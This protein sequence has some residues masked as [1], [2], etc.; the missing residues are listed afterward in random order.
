MF[1]AA[2]SIKPL[3]TM[4]KLWQV[5]CHKIVAP[6]SLHYVGRY[7]QDLL[8]KVANQLPANDPNRDVVWEGLRRFLVQIY[9]GV[10]GIDHSACYVNVCLQTPTTQYQTP[11]WHKDGWMFAPNTLSFKYVAAICG[12]PTRFLVNPDNILDEL[13]I[14][15]GEYVIDNR[16]VMGFTCGM[17]DSPIHSSPN[18]TSDRIF[19]SLVPGSLGQLRKLAELRGLP[20]DYSLF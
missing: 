5:D 17:P 6:K 4:G 16:Q 9:D 15:C 19:V 18:I 12:P 11:T 1:S 7:T 14:V 3:Y 20:V 10:D 2:R 13:P 8:H